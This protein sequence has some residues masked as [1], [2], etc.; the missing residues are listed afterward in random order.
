MQD[1]MKNGLEEFSVERYSEHR[2]HEWDTFVSTAKNATFLFLRGYMDYHSS[3]FADHSLMVFR[4]QKLVALL[5]ANLAANGTLISHEGLT[6]GGLV[7]PRAATLCQVLACFHAALRHLNRE[8]IPRL[9]YK[10]IPGF[11]NTLPYDEASYALFLLEAQL[12]RRDCATVVVQSDRLACRKGRKSDINRARRL[13]VH[14]VRE[15]AFQ[16]FWEHLLTPQLA[17]RYGVRPVHTLAEI[18]LLASRFP[19]N[20]RQFSAYCG[21]EIVAGVTI[22]ETPSVAHTQYAAVSEH[23]R[24]LDALALL[25]GW[26]MD[27]YYKDKRFFDFGISNEYNGR[28]INHGLLDWKEGFGGR[29]YVQDFYEVCPDN[30]VKLEPVL[31]AGLQTALNYPVR[32]YAM[33]VRA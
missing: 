26:L 13:G 18:T 5:P 9:I 6:Y 29:T 22:Y 14:V 23:G 15:T 12:C 19:E 32:N 21:D 1:T 2:C 3:R 16:A 33:A 31:P 10:Q 20:I 27:E 11:Y 17:R 24:Q 25:F 7:V 30:Y 28:A 4:G 8:H